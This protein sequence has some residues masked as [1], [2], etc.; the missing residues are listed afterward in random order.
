MKSHLHRHTFMMLGVGLLGGLGVLGMKTW[1]WPLVSTAQTCDP[2]PQQDV[3]KRLERLGTPF[4]T[5]QYAKSQPYA[6][7]VW[8]MYPFQNQVYLGHGDSN[9]NQG[10]IPLWFFDPQS[11]QFQFNFVAPEEQIRDFQRINATLY[12]PGIDSRESWKFGNIYRFQKRRW[13]KVRTLP[14]GVHVW[15]IQGFKR[16]LWSVIRRRDNRGYLLR[17]ANNGRTWQDVQTLRPDP[18]LMAQFEGS[19]YVFPGGSPWQIDTTLRPIHRTDLERTQLFPDHSQ[20]TQITKVVP[21]QSRL[22][23]LGHLSRYVSYSAQGAKVLNR[24]DPHLQPPGLFVARSL[25]PNQTQV[26][27]ISLNPNEVPWDL[28]ATRQGLY[29]LT[30]ER[31]QRTGQQ[32]FVNRVRQ[33]T[34]QDLW[35]EVLTF[36][37]DTFARSFTQLQGK[38][39]FGLGTDYGAAY[40]SK[41]YTQTAHP[42]AGTILRTQD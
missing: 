21:Y 39:Y 40:G 15:S 42:Q 36:E 7:N 22:A 9:A 14:G 37:S 5:G 2:L 26:R 13:Q 34:D 11:Q 25:K 1:L 28:V 24:E 19:L 10:P 20:A 18:A 4:A 17:S 6:R 3:T 30:S 16:Q 38:W 29:V 33:A 35:C 12:T 41:S 31:Q 27:R 32:R 8:V 23:Y